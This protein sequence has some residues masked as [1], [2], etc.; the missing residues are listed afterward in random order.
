MITPQQIIKTARAH[1]GEKSAG[2]RGGDG[3]LCIHLV[4]NVLAECGLE[5]GASE[6]AI[7]SADLRAGLTR[8]DAPQPGDVV[9]F[10]GT[11]YADDPGR[12]NLMGIATGGTKLIAAFGKAVGEY[13]WTEGTDLPSRDMTCWRVPA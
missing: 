2:Y 1:I 13:D 7:T 5:I 8:A 9:M 6:E 10:S 4:R 3:W 11:K 12:A